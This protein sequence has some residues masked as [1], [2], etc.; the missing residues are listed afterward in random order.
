MCAYVLAHRSDF[1]AAGSAVGSAA[2]AVAAV[3][4]NR[5]VGFQRVLRLD[6]LS[7]TIAPRGWVAADSPA[8]G[9]VAVVAALA[10]N[11]EAA[12]FASA[13]S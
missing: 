3:A 9:P 8:L 7:E 12:A 1:A 13:H 11:W 2:V 6:S 5:T 10:G 4:Q